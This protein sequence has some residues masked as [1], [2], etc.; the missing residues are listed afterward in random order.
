MGAIFRQSLRQSDCVLTY[1]PPWGGSGT[2]VKCPCSQQWGEGLG[3]GGALRQ[4]AQNTATLPRLLQG[5]S[6]QWPPGPGGE[7]WHQVGTHGARREDL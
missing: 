5:P 6:R 1:T 2:S 3:L 7:C 4:P